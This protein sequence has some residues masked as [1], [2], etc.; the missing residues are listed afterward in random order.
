VPKNLSWTEGGESL[1]IQEHLQNSFYH[2]NQYEQ[3]GIDVIDLSPTQITLA[4]NE[5][6]HRISGTW[7]SEPDE[8]LKQHEF[9]NIC[10]SWEGY[11]A[12]HGYLHKDARVG[13]AWI[14]SMEICDH[15]S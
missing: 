8:E 13:S 7:V 5:F 12:N 9:W 14:R 15:S 6:W 3:A 2:S 1:S 4:V 11:P 10:M